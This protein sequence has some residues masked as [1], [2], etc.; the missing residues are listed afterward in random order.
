MKL[1]FYFIL[2]LET[3]CNFSVALEPKA[4]LHFAIDVNHIGNIQVTLVN[5]TV[6]KTVNNFLA[7]GNGKQIFAI[8]LKINFNMSF[9]KE[10]ADL[11]TRIPSFIV[12]YLVS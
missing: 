1:C 2:I 7:L 6:P 9:A 8:S 3:V 10:S 4:K 5:G 11:V 12:S